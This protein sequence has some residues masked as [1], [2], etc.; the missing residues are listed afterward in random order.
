MTL[1]EL[2]LIMQGSRNANKRA[3][4]YERFGHGLE[5]V[6]CRSMLI[7]EPQCSP[8]A[9]PTT[10]KARSSSPRR[11]TS[12]RTIRALCWMI[13]MPLA[14]TFGGPLAPHAH[15]GANTSSPSCTKPNTTLCT[16]T[17]GGSMTKEYGNGTTASLESHDVSASRP[18]GIC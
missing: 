9:T 7:C 5:Q 8:S 14:L 11:K 13:S 16:R 2:C 10:S 3:A 18:T 12:S 4:M 1:Q 6:F 15:A 17:H